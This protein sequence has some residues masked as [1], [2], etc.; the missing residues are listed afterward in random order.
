MDLESVSTNGN[1]ITQETDLIRS[2]SWCKKVEGTDG[3]WNDIVPEV[4]QVYEA[5]GMRLTHGMCPPCY[6]ENAAAIPHQI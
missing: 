6:I 4:R 1:G 5:A 2:C 3:Q